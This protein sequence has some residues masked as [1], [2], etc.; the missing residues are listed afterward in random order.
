MD[1]QAS[2]QI[3]IFRGVGLT[4][5]EDVVMVSKQWGNIPCL[6]LKLKKLKLGLKVI[7][8]KV[9]EMREEL[10]LHHLGEV[11]LCHLVEVAIQYSN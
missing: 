2:N 9:F 1:I 6:L 11:V 8:L 10:H 5:G 3:V 7:K 4:I